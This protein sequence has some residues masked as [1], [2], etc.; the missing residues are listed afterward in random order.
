MVQEQERTRPSGPGPDEPE[1]CVHIEREKLT[2]DS[3]AKRDCLQTCPD[4][5][6]GLLTARKPPG[7]QFLLFIHEIATN[8]T[9]RYDLENIRS[10]Y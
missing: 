8:D 7:Y 10:D 9:A 3:P 2:G 4:I 6:G 5:S 1:P